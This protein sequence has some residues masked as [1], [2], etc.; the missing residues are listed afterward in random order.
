MKP[1][2]GIIFSPVSPLSSAMVKPAAVT[3][4]AIT[5][6]VHPESFSA[7]SRTVSSGFS[8]V[9]GCAVAF[10]AFHAVRKTMVINNN[11]FIVQNL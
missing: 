4:S 10:V 5:G 6:S 11:L 7:Y 2:P 8:P 1:L 3:F 9:L